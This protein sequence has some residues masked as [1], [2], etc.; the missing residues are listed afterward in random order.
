[1]LFVVT[2]SIKN[3]AG[4]LYKVKEDKASIVCIALHYELLISEVL[5]YG[6][7]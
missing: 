5:R 7:C 4:V 6:T 3:I 1:V 2:F